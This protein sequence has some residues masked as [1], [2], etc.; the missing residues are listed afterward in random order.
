MRARLDGKVALVTG[1]GT[2]I[3]R[4]VARRFAA[5]GAKVLILGRTEDTLVEAADGYD[6][7][8]YAVADLER[9]EDIARVLQE[10]QDR[11]GQLDV[12][13]NNA[14]WAPVTPISKVTMDEYDRV[15]GINVRALVNLTVRALPM[16]KATRGSVINMSSVICKNHL[17]NM[18]MYAGTKA[19]V[20]TFTKIWAKELAGDD[21]RVN[22]IGVGSIET[23]IYGKTDLSDDAAQMHMDAIRRAIPQGRFGQPADVAAVAAFLASDEAGFV[24]GSEYGV[25]GG[26]GA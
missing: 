3:G 21:V 18:S 4:A 12:L 11:Y 9:D 2:G 17:P 20:E 25:D 7:I 22:A 14:G 26:F 6:G 16:L 23:P 13:V 19:A 8:S 1:A 24:T 5:D 15:F 10:V